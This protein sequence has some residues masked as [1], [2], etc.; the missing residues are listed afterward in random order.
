MFSPSKIKQ[1]QINETLINCTNHLE[2]VTQFSCTLRLAF[3][4]CVKKVHTATD[5]DGPEGKESY[6]FALY[7][8][9]RLL[10]SCIY[11]E[12]LV[13]PE[14]L[15]SYIYGPTFDN[16]A[17]LFLFAAQCFNTES[18]QRGFLCHICV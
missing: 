7:L 3:C 12:L 5:H 17:S 15:T 1:F 8:T 9:L 18:M 14:M 16:A 2:Q 6:C 10:M 13:K 4:V 11:M